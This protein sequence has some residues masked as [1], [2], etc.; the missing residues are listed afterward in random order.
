MNPALTPGEWREQLGPWEPWEECLDYG[1]L[2][3]SEGR[4]WEFYGFSSARAHAAAAKCL[5][6]QPFG[7]TQGMVLDLNVA[8]S[9]IENHDGMDP[10]VYKL[11]NIRDRIEALLPPRPTGHDAR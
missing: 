4:F 11:K 3:L 9:E 2:P 7:F 1:G 6:G 5:Y 8:I 10:L